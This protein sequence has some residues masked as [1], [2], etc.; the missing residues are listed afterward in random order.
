MFPFSFDSSFKV[1][2]VDGSGT[3]PGIYHVLLRKR[4][5]TACYV[6]A[7]ECRVYIVAKITKETGHA[8]LINSNYILYICRY[9]LD[10]FNKVTS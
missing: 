2:K 8:I 5:D 9:I 4:E 1:A 3:G 10:D 6:V 7:K